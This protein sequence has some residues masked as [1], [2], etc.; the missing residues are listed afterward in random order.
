MLNPRDVEK[1]ILVIISD[2]AL[3]LGWIHTAVGLCHVDRGDLQARENIPW[4]S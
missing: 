4:H 2:E 1:V 3:H